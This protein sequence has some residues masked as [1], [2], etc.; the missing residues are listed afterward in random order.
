MLNNRTETLLQTYKPKMSIV[1]YSSGYDYYLES[2]TVTEDGKLSEGK[3]LLQETIQGIVDVFVNEHQ[4]TAKIKG[5]IPDNL[6]SFEL[7]PGGDY[8]MVWFRPAEIKF[9]HFA[10]QLKLKSAQAWVPAMLYVARNNTLGVFALK[11][12]T[13]PTDLTKL[14]RA[15]FHNVST[16]SGSVCLGSANVKKPKQLTY[17]SIQQY[18]EDLFWLS[19]FTH[20]NGVNPVKSKLFNVWKQ[21]LASK[22][23]LKWSDI[24]ELVLLENMSLKNIL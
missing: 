8:K 23:K 3:P 22:T 21:L 6:L 24:N 19:E 2:H 11:S 5:L 7:R 9:L 10:P 14:Y 15:P 17:A 13:R 16:D 12:N 20:L 18:W 4:N 1:V